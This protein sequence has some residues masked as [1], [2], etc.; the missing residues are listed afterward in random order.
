MLAVGAGVRWVNPEGQV[1][2]LSPGEAVVF[3]A[4]AKHAGAAYKFESGSAGVTKHSLQHLRF[5]AYI[6]LA[7]ERSDV[8]EL[9][10][11]HDPDKCMSGIQLD[12]S[13]QPCECNFYSERQ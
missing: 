9:S 5:H 11:I 10:R 3:D 4:N 8:E 13:I 1:I 7:D 2:D 6:D 12:G